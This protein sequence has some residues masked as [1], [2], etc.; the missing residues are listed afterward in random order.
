M[1]SEAVCRAVHA[2]SVSIEDMCIDYGWTDV[3]L[4]EDLLD[5]PNIIA[6]LKQM[7]RKRMLERVKSG[8]FGNVLVSEERCVCLRV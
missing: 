8:R 1:E 6:V 2:V 7:G 4:P 3:L 5:R